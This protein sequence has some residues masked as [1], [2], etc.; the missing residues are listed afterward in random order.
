RQLHPFLHDALPISV[1]KPNAGWSITKK[2]NSG[3]HEQEGQNVLYGDG[4]VTYQLTSLCGANGDHIYTNR[5][6]R[7]DQ[8]PVDKDDS[9]LVRSEEHTSELQSLAY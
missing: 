2:G 3:N 8:S 4:H 1:V 6:N 7:V 5:N 9:L